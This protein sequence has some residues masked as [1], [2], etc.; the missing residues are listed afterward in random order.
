MLRH[1]LS[2]TCFI[3]VLCFFSIAHGHPMLIVLFNYN[4]RSASAP[5]LQPLPPPTSKPAAPGRS[6]A[7]TSC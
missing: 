1:A 3:N 2:T 6:S 4:R 7:A 5:T